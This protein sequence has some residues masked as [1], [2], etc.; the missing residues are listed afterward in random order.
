MSAR[1]CQSTADTIIDPHRFATRTARW[2]LDT[3]KPGNQR[4]PDQ[5]WL[6][7]LGKQLVR[8]PLCCGFNQLE[9]AQPGQALQ[10]QSEGRA[11]VPTLMPAV[12]ADSHVAGT[13]QRHGRQK[14]RVSPPF[15]CQ[16]RAQNVHSVTERVSRGTVSSAQHA[17]R[18]TGRHKPTAARLGG[19]RRRSPANGGPPPTPAAGEGA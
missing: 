12:L 14:A 3:S 2:P 7:A 13:G 18:A 6:A 17:W 4:R 15:R 16:S 1:N 5:C 10:A 9:C 8:P 19:G 11:R